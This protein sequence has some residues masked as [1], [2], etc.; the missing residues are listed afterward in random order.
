MRLLSLIDRDAFVDDARQLAD[1]NRQ[2][3]Q[4]FD[5]VDAADKAVAQV[6]VVLLCIYR[7]FVRIFI[8]I[9]DRR[10]KLRMVQ[11]C[12]S[13]RRMSSDCARHTAGAA[14]FVPIIKYV[15]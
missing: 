7:C 6:L 13:W 9:C 5:A 4:L 15:F 2:L 11:A 14:K 12:W 1:V 3:R 10:S 8:Q